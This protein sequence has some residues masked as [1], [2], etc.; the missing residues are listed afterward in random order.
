[1]IKLKF[2]PN[3]IIKEDPVC[4][5]GSLRLYIGGVRMYTWKALSGG[6]GLGILPHGSYLVTHIDAIKDIKSNTPYK[7]EG[8]PWF[9]RIM[10][11]F[12]TY[13]TALGAHPE[14][15]VLGTLGCIGLLTEDTKFFKILKSLIPKRAKIILEVY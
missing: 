8:F 2:F 14:G 12:K 1:M 10:P 5:Q 11:Q 4:M 7:R 15:N 3:K 9:M 13:R 6:H